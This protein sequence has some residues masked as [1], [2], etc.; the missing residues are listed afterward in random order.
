VAAILTV[1][2][3]TG[4]YLAEKFPPGSQAQVL[5]SAALQTAVAAAGMTLVPTCGDVVVVGLD[6]A[7]TYQRLAEAVRSVFAGAGF[8]ATSFDSVLLTEQ[9]IA[10]GSGAIVAAI[11]ACVEAVPVCVG[12]PS[13]SMFQMA[14]RQLGL[15]AEETLVVGDSLV[16]DIAGGK[17]VGA[18][19]ALLLS[20]VPTHSG[21]DQL[22]PDLVLAGLRELSAFLAW[23]WET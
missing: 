15:L 12:K 17:A 19:T 14:A 23:S 5:G 1:S 6:A 22:Q 18:R 11:R 7:L 9:G 2:E 16:S 13:P 10:P 20:G 3:A 8:V 4:R 21:Q